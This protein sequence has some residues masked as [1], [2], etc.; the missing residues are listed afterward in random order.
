MEKVMYISTD[1]VIDI[2]EIESIE[3]DTLYEGVHGLVELV[4]LNRDVDMWVNEE[5]KLIGLEPNIIASMIWSKVFPNP[6]II[7]G[8]VVITGGADEE[9]NTVGLSDE[10]IQDI[11]ALIQD[12]LNI[13][14]NE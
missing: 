2:K 5:G 9:G 13:A 7:M 8:D 6:D 4:S 10:S 11:L 12:G 3:Y 14:N 1:N